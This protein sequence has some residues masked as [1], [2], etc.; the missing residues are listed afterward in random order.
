MGELQE[1][2]KETVQQ[3]MAK[4]GPGLLEPDMEL[5]CK[6]AADGNALGDCPFTHYIHVRLRLFSLSPVSIY[7]SGCHAVF[8]S[9]GWLH[10]IGIR[11]PY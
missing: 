4:A 10:G 3:E 9:D 11:V 1:E 7:P 2:K 6:A 8:A 5:F